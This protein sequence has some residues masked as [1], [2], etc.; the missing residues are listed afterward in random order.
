MVWNRTE[1]KKYIKDIEILELDE[2]P[3]ARLYMRRS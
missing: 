2:I 1:N 3:L